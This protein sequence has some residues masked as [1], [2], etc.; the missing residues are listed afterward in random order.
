M[1]AANCI[2][3]WDK[4]AR[5]FCLAHCGVNITNNFAYFRQKQSV[6]IINCV[7]T[8]QTVGVQ[9]TYKVLPGE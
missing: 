6:R 7:I 8:A 4:T 3:L 1:A 9:T 5:T 2:T